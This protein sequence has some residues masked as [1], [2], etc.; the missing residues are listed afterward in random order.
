LVIL[1]TVKV[2]NKEINKNV[3]HFL[4]RPWVLES[5]FFFLA[6]WQESF[7]LSSRTAH[8][9]LPVSLRLQHFYYYNFG[10]FVNG[11]VMAFIIDGLMNLLRLEKNT[12]FNIAG[13]FISKKGSALFATL[14]SV[15]IVVIFEITRSASVTSDIND[16]PAGILG[17]FIYY[18][19]RR[20]ALKHISPKEKP[21][22]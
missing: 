8:K 2:G 12:S 15:F 5:V 16:I 1:S 14:L 19:V 22:V 21:S 7:R 9:S 4:L 3:F 18:L 6:L 11:Y 17:A 20:F 10:D 13:F